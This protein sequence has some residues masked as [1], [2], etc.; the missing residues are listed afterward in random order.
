MNELKDSIWELVEDRAETRVRTHVHH[1]VWWNV[2]SRVV[3]RVEDRVRVPILDR[4]E[5]R[6]FDK[7]NR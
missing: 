5:E 4:V 2:G 7:V 1:L 3:Y 6:V